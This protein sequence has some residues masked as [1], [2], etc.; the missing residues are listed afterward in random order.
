MTP[1]EYVDALNAHAGGALSPAERDQ[2][3]AALDSAR[4]TRAQR[5]AQGG[6]DA[7]FRAARSTA[8]SC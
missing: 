5:A 4:E 7:D 3:V 6:R 2:L 8:P 1:D